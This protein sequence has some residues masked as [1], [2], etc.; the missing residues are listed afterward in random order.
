MAD[1]SARLDDTL[2]VWT[3]PSR[4][5]EESTPTGGCGV[6][7][8]VWM[9]DG[10]L[11]IYFQQSGTF[12]EHN[13]F[14]K[15][16][17]IRVKPT[18]KTEELTGDFVQTLDTSTGT[19]EL[20]W[21]R[22]DQAFGATVW[23]SQLDPEFFVDLEATPPSGW[24]VGYEN[25]R[26]E[27][28]VSEGQAEQSAI[29]GERFDIFGYVRYPH[30]LIRHKDVVDF[31]A[32]GA[33]GYPGAAIRF[34]HRNDNSDLAFDK[35]MDQQGFAKHKDRLYNPQRDLIFGG[36]VYADGARQTGTV[37][38]SYLGTPYV[39]HCLSLP[40]AARHRVL[41]LCRVDRHKSLAEWWDGVTGRRAILDNSAVE[42]IRLATATW[43]RRYWERSHIRIAPRESREDRNRLASQVSK[44]YRLFRFM[45]GVNN[46]GLFPTKFNG[47]L[48]P[49]DS[50][51]VRDVEM[52]RD[53][54]TEAPASTKRM[55]YG[56]DFRAWGGGSLTQQNQRLIYWPMIKSGD[57]DLMASQLDWYIDVLPAA[58]LRSEVSWGHA[59]C[60]FTEQVNNFGL[61]IGS[62][63]GWNRDPALLQGEQAHPFVNQHYYTQLEF[64]WMMLTVHDYTGAIK[65]EYLTF[66]HSAT[67]FF[68][69]H[70]EYAAR[71]A[72]RDAYDHNGRLIIKPS[73]ALETY[74][75]ATTPPEV[76][77]AL[78]SIYEYLVESDLIDEEERDHYRHRLG[79]VPEIPLRKINGKT[80]IAPAAEWTE[81]RNC[82]LPQLYPVYPYGQIGLG[83]SHL[84]LARDT[85]RIGS[86]DAACQK[87][88]VSWHQCGIFCARMGLEDEAV[89]YLFRKLADS[90]RRFP[91]FWGPGADWVPDHNW[92]GSGMIQLQ[93]MLIQSAGDS[94][95]ILPCWPRAWDVS[96]KLHAPGATIVECEY[97][98]G[99]IALLAVTP[100]SRRADVR[101][102]E[103]L[104]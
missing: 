76:I 28:R 67:E 20:R 95:L 19:V 72:G 61:P 99:T 83:H 77:V 63:Y 51:L 52:V 24:T 85:W 2:V 103:T 5:S 102:P 94:I 39:R 81:V 34:Y 89:W 54:G 53:M 74:W 13:G 37:K 3:E 104:L 23:A 84:S 9:E 21:T 91:A 47:G 41:C 65:A 11:L 75:G 57:F 80:C 29:F 15:L 62:H 14:P 26:F 43:W 16:G 55:D 45:L 59:G 101:M 22:G 66:I 82:E 1:D 38:G 48:H 71:E 31:V 25:W 56:P 70:Y 58:E 35:E 32:A 79:C 18:A 69:L 90:G 30:D 8:N 86:Q 27:D 12:D 78:R 97:R 50:G 7:L 88:Y 100:E 6:G 64:A 93:E 87:G 68:F 33:G 73:M 96:F 60:S 46:G 42:S 36:M 92:G 10:D 98:D 17:R 4:N 49:Y 40:W 44:N